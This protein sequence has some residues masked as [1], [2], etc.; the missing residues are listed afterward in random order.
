MIKGHN[1]I[2]CHKLKSFEGTLLNNDNEIVVT[3]Y[4]YHAPETF[5]DYRERL[6]KNNFPDYPNVYLYGH[7]VFNKVSKLFPGFFVQEES[8]PYRYIEDFD[9]LN[10][11]TPYLEGFKEH[12]TQ[13]ILDRY[14]L[15]LEENKPQSQ[16]NDQEVLGLLSKVKHRCIRPSIAECDF[17]P[18]AVAL[19]M[20]EDITDMPLLL[21]ISI[22]YS[23]FGFH[24]IDDLICDYLYKQSF[25]WFRDNQR[26]FIFYI[27]AGSEEVSRFTGYEVEEFD[28]N[29]YAISNSENRDCMMQPYSEIF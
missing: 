17:E 27:F 28:K 23:V 14:H 25:V 22:I 4:Q 1:K 8:T 24:N 9:R 26:R 10:R 11:K 21:L 19:Y 6:I 29:D 3:C 16:L 2:T 13:R 15:L 20:I 5:E 7:T 12:I 18:M